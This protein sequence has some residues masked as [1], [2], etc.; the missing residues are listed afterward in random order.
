MTIISFATIIPLTTTS[1]TIFKRYSDCERQQ[2]MY[3]LSSSP[4][5]PPAGSPAGWRCAPSRTDRSRSPPLLSAEASWPW[6]PTLPHTVAWWSEGRAAL[7]GSPSVLLKSGRK[8]ERSVRKTVASRRW[9]GVKF[10]SVSFLFSVAEGHSVQFPH[11]NWER[12]LLFNTG[13]CNTWQITNNISLWSV[14]T[15]K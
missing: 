10:V 11:L 13:S 5:P 4:S 6:T 15:E 9:A 12:L 3:S 1:V 14:V 7:A 2:G 8:G